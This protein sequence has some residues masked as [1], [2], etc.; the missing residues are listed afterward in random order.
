MSRRI[1]TLDAVKHA[2][3]NRALAGDARALLADIADLCVKEGYCFARDRYFATLYGV[4]TRSV[5]RWVR[6]L[7]EAGYIDRDGDGSARQIRMSTRW[8]EAQTL[9]KECDPYQR[10]TRTIRDRVPIKTRTS[11][12]Q[13]SRTDPGPHKDIYNP[14]RVDVGCERNDD[15][16]SHG[17]L[18]FLPTGDE[19]FRALI[20]ETLQLLGADR[21]LEALKSKTYGRGHGLTPVES[22]ALRSYRSD[23]GWVKLVAA[24]TI[25]ASLGIPIVKL[26]S[27]TKQ[28]VQVI[29]THSAVEVWDGREDW[30]R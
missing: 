29:P 19:R 2:R 3:R 11:A 5:R 16:D 14:D 4:S 21:S 28:W 24:C 6:A 10:D 27:V 22:R 23:L 1:E 17:D 9:A 12:D 15:D 26:D 25:G 18:S 30:E 13:L 7:D 8:Q 20:L